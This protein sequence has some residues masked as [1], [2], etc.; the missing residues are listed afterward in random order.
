MKNQSQYLPIYFSYRG[1]GI[2]EVL[3]LFSHPGISRNLSEYI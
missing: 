2:G 1:E 3:G